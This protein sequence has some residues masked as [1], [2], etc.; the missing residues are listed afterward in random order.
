MIN[1]DFKAPKIE[2]IIRGFRQTE[3]N[4]IYGEKTTAIINN[5]IKSMHKLKPI[6]K[7]GENRQIWVKADKGTIKDFGN[8]KELK[9]DGYYNSKKEFNE[10]WELSWPDPYGWFSVVTVENDC[11]KAIRLEGSFVYL[12]VFNQDRNTEDL[13][14]VYMNFFLWLEEAVND[15][16]KLVRDNT[17]N[18]DVKANLPFRNRYGTIDRKTYWEIFRE[19]KEYYYEDISEEEIETFRNY[20]KDQKD[21]NEVG[22]YLKE[23]TVNKFLD[24]CALGYKENKFEGTDTLSPREQYIKYS[25]GRHGGLLDLDEDSPSA[26]RDWHKNYIGHEHYYEVCKGHHVHLDVNYKENKGYY[27]VLSGCDIGNSNEVIKFYNA[28]R[29]LGI[30]I[31]LSRKE[32]LS[33]RLFGNDRVGILPRQILHYGDCSSCF[34]NMNVYDAIN[35]PWNKED[36][37]K[38]IPHITWIEER[39]TTFDDN[40]ETLISFEMVKDVVNEVNE[41]CKAQGMTFEESIKM[42]F[43]E[44]VY[45]KGLP[46]WFSIEDLQKYKDEQIINCKISDENE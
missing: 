9:K 18:Q 8:Y 2:R 27:L 46:P 43:E 38:I 20:I 40:L 17:Y 13:Q 6:D 44:I 5:I 37:D 31:Y 33:G 10:D 24:L 23:M 29:P 41:I 22:Q 12:N 4:T 34:P 7:D 32:V 42:F 45:Y 39:E 14:E 16:I 30:A 26:F 21:D 11:A 35:L 36:Y 25:D 28:L 3:G 1:N 15:A 19:E